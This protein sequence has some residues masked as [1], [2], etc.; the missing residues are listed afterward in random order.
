MSGETLTY[1]GIDDPIQLWG[2]NTSGTEP[3]VYALAFVPQAGNIPNA[4]TSTLA[5][6]IYGTTITW[7]NCLIDKIQY[8]RQA[9]GYTAVAYIMDRRWK[10][11]NNVITGRYNVRLSDGTV[12]PAT[13]KT[14]QQLATLLLTAFGEGATSVSALVND[15][16]PEVDWNDSVAVD[17]L[18]ALLESRGCVIGIPD[19]V[20]TIALIGAGTGAPNN[21]DIR[22]IQQTV[23]PPLV[24]E[25]LRLVGN[26]TVIQSKLR[27]TAIGLETD[28]SV[29]GIDDLSYKPAGGW[30]V[31]SDW[32]TFP[33]ITNEDARQRAIL[34]VG[35]WFQVE[36]QA[37]GG[38]AIEGFSPVPND[39]SELMPLSTRLIGTYADIDGKARPQ[40]AWVEG[41]FWRT[42]SPDFEDGNSEDFSRIRGGWRLLPDIGV[43]QFTQPMLMLDESTEEW[44]AAQLYLVCTYSVLNPSTHQ[45]YRESVD[46][47]LGGY[48][49]VPIHV[50]SIY[51]TIREEYDGETVT[52]TDDN[53]VAFT[54]AANA[55][56]DAHE[57]TYTVQDGYILS[58][59]HIQSV[60]AN[61][62]VSQ[63]FWR[64]G[65]GGFFTTVAVANEPLLGATKSIERLRRR[66]VRQN[67]DYEQ[68]RNRRRRRREITHW[69]TP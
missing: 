36:S 23:D 34:S 32:L 52:Y 46:R 18:A 51:R 4:G 13:E 19:N 31:V 16:R 54:A 37:D 5:F 28:D 45:Y 22:S 21:D 25:I 17:E 26:D 68:R 3:D 67:A 56:L 59:R 50:E 30:S 61:G 20:T 66:L 53:L 49:V 44:V 55:I 64:A 69:R 7:T 24:P 58:Y 8:S 10:W 33:E 40:R 62:V 2:A 6:G 42:G 27:L 47:N 65:T 48:G 43:V 63:V 9:K 39:S 38:Q 29:I 60:F 41:T 11:R 12:D 15:D 14:P 1:T 35:K 57:A